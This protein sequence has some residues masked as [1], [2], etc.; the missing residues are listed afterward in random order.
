MEVLEAPDGRWQ[1]RDIAEGAGMMTLLLLPLG[2]TLTAPDQPLSGAYA[3]AGGRLLDA[4]G[5]P[6]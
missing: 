1:W 2:M 3:R 5:R 4:A 6:R